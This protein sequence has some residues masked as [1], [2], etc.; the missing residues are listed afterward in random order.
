MGAGLA[1]LK[2]TAS[3]MWAPGS[4]S[5]GAVT[6]AGGGVGACQHLRMLSI[7]LDF[8]SPALPH[9]ALLV[10]IS[11]HLPDVL[12]ELIFHAQ[13]FSLLLVAW[14]NA[15]NMENTWPGTDLSICPPLALDFHSRC[16]G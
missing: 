14:T 11:M 8:R 2:P 4:K 9:K 16:W 7:Q 5:L 15:R 12:P 6:V 10:C 1:K 3:L 13:S